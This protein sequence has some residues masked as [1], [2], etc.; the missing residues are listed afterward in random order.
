M[1][2]NPKYGGPTHDAFIWDNSAVNDFMQ[3]LHRNNEQVSLLGKYE[4]LS[5]KLKKL[6]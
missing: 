5:L 2:V 1:N 6:T 3:S 4:L